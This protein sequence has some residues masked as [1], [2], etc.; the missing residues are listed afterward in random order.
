[1]SPSFQVI[2]PQSRT[3]ASVEIGDSAAQSTLTPTT[4]SQT[5]TAI[6]WQTT[7]STEPRKN[8]PTPVILCAVFGALL[9]LATGWICIRASLQAWRKRAKFG[10]PTPFDV[11]LDHVEKGCTPDAPP[12]CH[13]ESRLQ[14]ASAEILR[15]VGE[16]TELRAQQPESSRAMKFLPQHHGRARS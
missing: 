5:S 4:T 15:L 1:M 8:S 2:Y 13:L 3:T 11:H 16:M 12:L 6:T 9:F 10:V 7:V 14:A